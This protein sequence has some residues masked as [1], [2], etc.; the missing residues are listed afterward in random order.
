LLRDAVAAVGREIGMPEADTFAT[1]SA[2]WPEIVG[3]SLATHVFLR[4]VHDGVCTVEVD[5]AG[6]TTQLRYA[7]SQIVARAAERCGPGIVTS[8]RAVVST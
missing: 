7:E 3:N 1:L 2:S 8:I 6:W 4:S 5:G